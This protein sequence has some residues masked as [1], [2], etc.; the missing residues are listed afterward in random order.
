MKARS[1]YLPNWWQSG[2]KGAVAQLGIVNPCNKII[3]KKQKR[4]ASW[5]DGRSIVSMLNPQL[6]DVFSSV[7]RIARLVN[8]DDKAAF[9][10][11]TLGRIERLMGD[12]CHK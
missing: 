11:Q 3:L 4:W 6:L 5:Q 2:Q 8:Q 12:T 1:V 7:Q 9:I 10:D